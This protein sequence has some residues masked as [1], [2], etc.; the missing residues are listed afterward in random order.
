M[1]EKTLFEIPIYTMS[2][3]KFNKRWDIKQ[4]KLYN[5]FLR[6]GNTEQRI[7]E[8]LRILW[9]PKCI[10]KY[11]QIIGYIVLS[12]TAS[13]VLFDLYCSL[14][15]KFYADSKTKHFI[16]SW[17]MGGT[18]FYAENK[19]EDDIKREI[20]CWLSFIE[21]EHL[22]SR[23]YIDYST[24]YNVFNFINIKEIMSTF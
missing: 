5:E 17:A 19:T 7:H 1:N 9:H 13:D 24:F 14:D 12:V 8:I 22:K 6:R 16:Q 23:F 10:W 21:K 18:H 2:A 3:S 4:A 15:K 20:L 11:N